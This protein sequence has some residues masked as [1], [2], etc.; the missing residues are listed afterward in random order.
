MTTINIAQNKYITLFPLR[1]EIRYL[2]GE[3]TEASFAYREAVPDDDIEDCRQTHQEANIE[4]EIPGFETDLD[5]ERQIISPQYRI[6][7]HPDDISLSVPAKT[8]TTEETE[9]IKSFFTIFINLKNNTPTE[10]KIHNKKLIDKLVPLDIRNIRNLQNRTL[11]AEKILKIY[12]G[13]IPGKLEKDQKEICAWYMQNAQTAILFA[14]NQYTQ[15][16]SDIPLQDLSTK[17]IGLR[18]GWDMYDIENPVLSLAWQQLIQQL[19]ITRARYLVSRFFDIQYREMILDQ[20]ADFLLLAQK[21][22]ILDKAQD[23][24]V[25]KILSEGAHID[26]MPRKIYLFTLKFDATTLPSLQKLTEVSV[27]NPQL[28]YVGN[29]V[30][31]GTD[32]SVDF[33]KAVEK[34]MGIII[35]DTEKIQQI[36]H[37]DWLVGFGVY[38][39]HEE[40]TTP[41]LEILLKNFHAQNTLRVAL[42]DTPTNN[43]EESNSH[44]QRLATDFPY[45]LSKTKMQNMTTYDTETLHQKTIKLNNLLH[46]EGNIT[47]AQ[48]LSYI[49]EINPAVLSEIPGAESTSQTDEEAM[50]TLLWQICTRWTKDVWKQPVSEPCNTA[51][52]AADQ[53]KWDRYWE[54]LEKFFVKFVRAGGALPV[55]QAGATPYGIL[56]I[57]NLNHFIDWENSTFLD[58]KE[59]TVLNYVNFFCQLLIS[60]FKSLA[61]EVSTLSQQP[62]YE[63]LLEILRLS[64]LSKR[65]DI[66]ELDVSKN[67]YEQY[68][69]YLLSHLVKDT[70]SAD[71]TALGLGYL[72]ALAEGNIKKIGHEFKIVSADH[73]LEWPTDMND[74]PRFSLLHR[75]LSLYLYSPQEKSNEEMLKNKLQHIQNAAKHLLKFNIKKLECL[76]TGVLD[77]LSFRVDAWITA[78]ATLRLYECRSL[79]GSKHGAIGVYGWLEKPGV[80]SSQNLSPSHE[81]VPIHEYLQAPSLEQ[82]S[83][84][85]LLRNATLNQTISESNNNAPFTFNL[86]SKQVSLG[87]N[88]LES[89][90]KGYLIEEILGYRVERM[91]HAEAISAYQSVRDHYPNS[92]QDELKEK[93]HR[94]IEETDI[95]LLRKIFRLPNQQNLE[96]DTTANLING[97][98]FIE[99]FDPDSLQY[100]DLKNGFLQTFQSEGYDDQTSN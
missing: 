44:Y 67:E 12:N 51:C 13:L 29:N 49:L 88:Y 27:Q 7:W 74:Q 2:E 62:E 77:L 38:E 1:F 85:A 59:K 69:S 48:L 11:A 70:I 98:L 57:A 23:N 16:L 92:N 47:D 26:I 65:V 32:W 50:A 84:T 100:N 99:S 24:P 3:T 54:I 43:T 63:T 66:R 30:T 10:M 81:S 35:T 91:I 5:F 61:D 68:S 25:Q 80:M 36:H 4:N 6:R 39:D 95:Y 90:K 94:E 14:F 52:Q 82:A 89:I 64:S 37:A 9:A 73:I 53:A 87:L 71:D 55:L 41:N 83:A 72:Y 31:A 15:E 22:N 56:P 21:I 96:S 60:E 76:M 8:I 86:S 34:G 42:Q 45:Y 19:G 18:M 46:P 79:P 17:L 75:L 93:L 97:K 33:K 28:L 40:I 58:G 78:L 20:T